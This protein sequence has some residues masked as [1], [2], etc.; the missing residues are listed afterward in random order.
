M[1]EFWETAFSNKQ[2][3]WGMSP[4]KSAELTL[5]LFKQKKIKHILIPGIGYGRNAK[6]FIEHGISVSGIEV[7]KT[8]IELARK[9]YK[10]QIKLFHGSVTNMPFN[11]KT[12]DGI[13]CYALIHL[14]NREARRKLIQD[15][16]NQL[17]KNGFMV[18]TAITKSAP[19]YGQGKLIS[20]DRYETHN[21][22][23]IFYYNRESVSIEFEKYGLFDIVEVDENQPMYLIK[24]QKK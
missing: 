16:Y 2:E 24:C 17:T 8:A 18:F 7:S 11:N 6:P 14:L 3:M 5:N 13:F 20:K 19:Q 21:G 9:H 23:K 10:S 12:Y 15:C 22:A 4:A 1:A